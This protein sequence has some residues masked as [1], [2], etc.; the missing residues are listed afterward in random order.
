MGATDSAFT[1]RDDLNDILAHYGV[2]GMKWGV[3]RRSSVPDGKVQ[4]SQAKPGAKLK[5]AGGKGFKADPDAIAARAS[6]Q[7]VKKSGT[8]ALSNKELQALVT[9]MNLEQQYSN[10]ATKGHKDIYKRLEDG[11]KKAKILA[12]TGDSLKTAAKYAVPVALFF[13]GA[14]AQ[15]ARTGGYGSATAYRVYKPA[16]AIAGKTVKAITSR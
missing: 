4:V 6:A 8:A 10:L 3:R 2:K 5:T 12:K 1:P 9:R 14:A 7:V 15:N 13:A 16:G 11:Q